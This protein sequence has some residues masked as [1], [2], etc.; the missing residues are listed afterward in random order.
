MQKF[1]FVCLGNICRSP[2]ADGVARAWVARQNLNW[3]IDS[4][5]TGAWHAGAPPDARMVAAAARRGLDL[6]DLRARQAVAEDF[7]TFDHVF[8]MDR[9]NLADLRQIQPPAAPGRLDLFLA[10]GDIPDPYYG[11]DQGFEQVLDQIE[12][13]M[14]VLLESIRRG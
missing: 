14:N 8:A 10:D 4:A 9:Q 13:R 12:A 7:Q 6:T 1:L 5:G 3:Q 2:A 11:G